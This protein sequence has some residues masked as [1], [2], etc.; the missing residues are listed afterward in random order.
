MKDLAL[1]L[2]TMLRAIR[3]SVL[4]LVLHMPCELKKTVGF[5]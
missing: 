5:L 1:I 4:L 2:Q 3:T